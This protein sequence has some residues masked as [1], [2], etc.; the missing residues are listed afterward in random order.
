MELLIVLNIIALSVLIGF[1]LT[2]A[3]DKNTQESPDDPKPD[4][5]AAKTKKC[6][7]CDAEIDADANRCTKCGVIFIFY[8]AKRFW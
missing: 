8:K 5:I 4:K 3:D 1:L 2:Y 6:P 7:R